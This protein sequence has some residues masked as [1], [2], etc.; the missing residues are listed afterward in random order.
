MSSRPAAREVEGALTALCVTP[1]VIDDFVPV[2]METYQKRKGAQVE[3]L[4]ANVTILENKA[5]FVDA[6]TSPEKSIDITWPAAR[7]EDHLR[8]E[9]YFGKQT[10]AQ[11]A[12]AAKDGGEEG[13][14]EPGM[15]FRS[16]LSSNS[17]RRLSCVVGP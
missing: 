15:N 3:A 8:N 14:A 10:A 12:A 9:G 16:V 7:I 11:A 6:I 4:E 17:L 13:E 1:Q 5:R 2:R